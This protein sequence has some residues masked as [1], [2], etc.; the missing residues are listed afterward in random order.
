MRERR[1]K[2]TYYVRMSDA[3]N[4]KINELFAKGGHSQMQ[5]QDVQ[6]ALDDTES[7]LQAE[8]AYLREDH[9][10]FYLYPDS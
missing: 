8:A 9:G 4:T 1:C 2:R 10:N 7:D 3:M 5:L 6:E